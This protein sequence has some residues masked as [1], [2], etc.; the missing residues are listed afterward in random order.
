MSLARPASA[1]RHRL[2]A[3]LAWLAAFT[4]WLWCFRVWDWN[5]G[6]VRALLPLV[7]L[8]LLAALRTVAPSVWP[9]PT[10]RSQRVAFLVLAL[11]VLANVVVGVLAAARTARTG[12]IRLDQGQNTYR[13]ALGLWRGENPYGQGAMLDRAGFETR[14]S[15]RKELGVGPSLPDDQVPEALERYWQ[16]MD[17]A[18]REQLLPKAPEGSSA[19]ARREVAL[20]GYKYGPVLVLAT[21]L[22]A[23][24]FGPAAVPLLNLACF[25]GWLLALGMLAR[26]RGL[27]KDAV[28]LSLLAVAVDPHTGWNYVALTASDV[29]V[30]LFG[31]LSLWAHAARRPAAFGALLA[32]A[33]G[34][35]LFPA[36]ALVPLLFFPRSLR[37][38]GAF[39]LCAAAL[40]LPWLAWDAGGVYNNL[41]LWPGLMAPDSTSWA[42]HLPPGPALAVRLCLLA[43][44][45]VVGLRYLLGREGRLF[46]SLGLVHLCLASAGVALHNNYL[47]WFSAFAF[48][49]VAEALATPRDA[50]AGATLAACPAPAPPSPR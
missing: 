29:W 27:P 31:A 11:A 43:L 12:D 4:G 37:A 5:G 41:V 28:A 10:A 26:R 34:C 39:A 50:G 24:L 33:V 13:A 3:L 1:E 18:L 47:P 9:A 22:P 42:F 6:P 14:L 35:K 40:Y 30:L 16:S 45:A 46:W 44:M 7:G 17:P 2:P 49:A 23:R 8:L 25:V 21:A 19:A 32:I 15:L 38:L 48:L 20:L 36:L